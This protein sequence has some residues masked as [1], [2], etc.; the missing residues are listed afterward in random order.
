MSGGAIGFP[1]KPKNRFGFPMILQKE[2]EHKL[3]VKVTRGDINN[4]NE[5]NRIRRTVIIISTGFTYFF[6]EQSACFEF[7]NVYWINFYQMVKSFIYV[8]RKGI[9]D[10]IG[11]ETLPQRSCVIR[12][13]MTRLT[14]RTH[15]VREERHHLNVT[16]LHISYH[17]YGS[18]V[19]S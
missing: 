16:S 13:S 9:V 19:L 11:L 12:K 6:Q 8:S 5:R 2:N 3:T 17:D 14:R 10:I 7:A 18:P 1:K 15:G 4:R